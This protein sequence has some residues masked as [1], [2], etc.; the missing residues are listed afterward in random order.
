[1]KQ[2]IQQNGQNGINNQIIINVEQQNINNKFVQSS[3]PLMKNWVLSSF[4]R[5]QSSMYLA[6]P[7]QCVVLPDISLL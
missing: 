5:K 4:R 2:R 3:I 7:S 6:S 1:M